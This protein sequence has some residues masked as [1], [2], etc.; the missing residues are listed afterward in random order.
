MAAETILAT[1]DGSG[2]HQRLQVV[3]SQGAEGGLTIVLCEQHHG[4]EAIGWFD[5][6]RLKLDPRQWR[7]LQAV[8]GHPQTAGQLAQAAEAPRTTIPFPGPAVRTPRRA[9]VGDQG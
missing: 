2:P 4:G 6:R 1:L 3:L 5:Q 9:A 7:Q 8:L